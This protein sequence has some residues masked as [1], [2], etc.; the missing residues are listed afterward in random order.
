MDTTEF[1]E[2]KFITA[3]LVKTSPTKV[4]VILDEAKPE[5]TDFGEKLQVHVQIDQKNKIWR[6]NRD[7]VKNM[8]KINT[9]SKFWIGKKVQLMTI[10]MK[11]KETVI[12]LPVDD[13]K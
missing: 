13:A 4:C 6:I 2:G 1:S 3:E 9:D 7:S 12:G 8:H 11:G 5:E 10:T